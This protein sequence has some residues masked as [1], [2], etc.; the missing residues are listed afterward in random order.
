MEGRRRAAS[1]RG[2]CAV[3]V[4]RGGGGHMRESRIDGHDLIERGSEGKDLRF[5][6]T[7]KRPRAKRLRTRGGKNWKGDCR[8][9]N[10]REGPDYFSQIFR[11]FSVVWRGGDGISIRS[12]GLRRISQEFVR[13]G[14]MVVAYGMAAKGYRE[15][16][17]RLWP[18][19]K[20]I[21]V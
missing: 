14:R 20:P 5:L 4:A 21:I 15:I 6:K 8:D 16:H 9:S 3:V 1:F 19:L 17:H 13:S 2:T 7:Q 10:L 12:I 18:G 11:L